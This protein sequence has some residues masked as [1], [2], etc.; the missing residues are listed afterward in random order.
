VEPS[1]LQTIADL[2]AREHARIA[3]SRGKEQAMA[4]SPD[5]ARALRDATCLLDALGV[6]D[7]LVGGVAVGLRSGVPRATIDT[8]LAVS[9]RSARS[10][11]V[12]ALVDQADVALLRG[13]VPDPDEGW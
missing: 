9:S 4:D 7:A 10:G 5:K 13:D 3:A 8:D 11:V 6:P 1:A 12:E 2:S